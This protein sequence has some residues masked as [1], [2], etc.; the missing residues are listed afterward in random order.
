MGIRL[1]MVEGDR[2]GLQHAAV[3]VLWLALL[4]SSG[5]GSIDDKIRLSSS[6]KLK[7]VS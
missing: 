3:L 6:G 5:G 2:V 4:N 1:G 7:T